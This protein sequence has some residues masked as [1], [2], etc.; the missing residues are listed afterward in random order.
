MNHWQPNELNVICQMCSTIPSHMIVFRYIKLLS[1]AL[2]FFEYE[3]KCECECK[4]ACACVVKFPLNEERLMKKWDS[5]HFVCCCCCCNHYLSWLCLNVDFQ[6][7]FFM[8]AVKKKA[9]ETFSTQRTMPL[10]Y[11]RSFCL[12][13]SFSVFQFSSSLVSFIFRW[14]I[15]ITICTSRTWC[16]KI[17]YSCYAQYW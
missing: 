16:N 4:C 2:C 11:I 5:S 15:N 1:S 12:I 3:Y 17:C 6:D 10:A 13:W 14:H 8:Y 7:F 9:K